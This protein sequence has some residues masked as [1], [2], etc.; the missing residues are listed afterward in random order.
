MSH[1]CEPN[2]ETEEVRMGNM[3]YTVIKAVKQI[4]TDEEITINYGWT[5][6]SEDDLNKC[7]C[8][9][10]KCKHFLNPLQPN[11][12]YEL[13]LIFDKKAREVCANKI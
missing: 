8:K 2:C 5:F 10:K 13:S 3:Y 11:S 4:V 6:S 9:S 1:S 12:T 7:F